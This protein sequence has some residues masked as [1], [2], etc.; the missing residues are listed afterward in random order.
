MAFISWSLSD[1]VLALRVDFSLLLS[2]FRG[3]RRVKKKGV[4]PLP[5][6]FPLPPVNGAPAELLDTPALDSRVSNVIVDKT[7]G[8]PAAHSPA[9]QQRLP[10]Y[11]ELHSPPEATMVMDIADITRPLDP[12]P[13]ADSREERREVRRG[14]RE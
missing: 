14:L 7:I 8:E 5:P 4:R 10:P 11:L 9:P 1:G 12:K 6:P 2:V 3:S 13:Q